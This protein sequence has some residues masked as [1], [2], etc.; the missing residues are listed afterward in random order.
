MSWME[1]LV[2]TY[3][4]NERFAGRDDV[5]GMKV[6]LSPIGYSIHDAWLEVVLR[7]NGEFIDAFELPKEER[8]TPMPCTPYPRT[9][10]P[11]PHP[12]FDNLSYVSRD[13]QK[14]IE[15]P[16]SKDRESYGAY[17]ELLAKW[18]QQED[19]PLIVRAVYAYISQHDLI[20]D[21]IERK[22]ATKGKITSKLSSVVRFRIEG[23]IDPW[24]D[25]EV[26]DS[27][28][29]IYSSLFYENASKSLCYG[30]GK[31]M[32]T[33]EKPDTRGI[34]THGDGTRLISSNDEDN[35]TFRGR[36]VLGKECLSIGEETVQK[37]MN[38]LR[39]LVENQGKNVDGRVFLAWGRN[40]VSIPSVFDDTEGL[41]HKRRP[42]EA[43]QPDTLKMWAQ[44]L[45]KAL[46]G[47]R[48]DFR[49]AKTSQV[50]VIILDAVTDKG[51][52]SICYYSEMAGED[53]IERIEKWHTA[54]QWYQ[55]NQ[56]TRD[57]KNPGWYPPYFGVP[58]PRKLVYAYRG[59][60]V[61]D[62]QMKMELH[63]IFFSIVQGVPLPADM[64]RM[65]FSRVVKRAICDPLEKWEHLILEPACSIICNRLNRKKEVYTVALNERK[66]NRSYLFGRLLAVADQ[67]E[68]ETFTAEEKGS[69]ITNAM[70]YMN[71]FSSRPVSTWETIQKKLLP[72]QAKREKYGGKEI[73]LIDE[74]ISMFD[75]G[76]FCSNAPLEV[77]F[78]L[79]LSCQRH[80]L[81]KEREENKKDAMREE[82][83]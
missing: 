71:I 64:E 11:V 28:K 58:S 10:G 8:A 72:Y 17:K 54:G 57:K 7:E 29:K 22:I 51:R 76:D 78:L 50:N 40:S 66:I 56:D 59:D 36:F 18:V 38:A 74:I 12:L 21:L 65:A 1:Q 31:M 13:Y 19:S 49:R 46:D 37:S 82:N 75:D 35:F 48:H 33:I 43:A 3:D 53:F 79:G 24:R 68:R 83:K 42:M 30:S 69:R 4:E 67:M 70:R 41:I 52:L 14:F 15:N 6:A 2:Q 20:Y 45:H 80:A 27:Y 5:E 55:R 25:K 47:Y 9:S 62:K 77:E 73:A 60:N 39:W 26:Q 44:N 81:R 61:S 34:R 63:R 16:S 32:V 23:R